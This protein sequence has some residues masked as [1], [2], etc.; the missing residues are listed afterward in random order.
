MLEGDARSLLNKRVLIAGGAGFIGR[1]LSEAALVGGAQIVVLDDFSTG[2]RSMFDCFAENGQVTILEADIAK[3]L[4]EL[5][6]CDIVLNLASPASPLV[7][8]SDPLGTW[9]TNVYGTDNLSSL[10]LA[11][12]AVFVQASTSEVYGDPAIHPQ[13]ETYWGNTNPVGTRSCYDEGKRAAETLTMDLVRRHGLNGRIARIFNTYG[14]GMNIDD[15]RLLPNLISQ[16]LNGKSLTLYGDGSQTRS[17][18]Y[19]D[20]LVAGLI[21]MATVDAAHGE[22]INLGN[23]HEL[24]VLEIAQLVAHLLAHDGHIVHGPL[25]LDDPIRRCPDVG[26]AQRLLGWTPTTRLN[27]GLVLMANDFSGRAVVQDLT[28]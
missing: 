24:T 9:R 1:H 3:S 27:E 12:D 23:P 8:Q 17:L 7:Y 26:K 4:P 22:V 25:P 28:A 20:D 21:L 19:V 11:W 6:R 15:G 2:S 13:P 5:Q 14:P 16:A 10:A 18:C